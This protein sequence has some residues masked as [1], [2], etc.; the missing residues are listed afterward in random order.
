MQKT[1]LLVV[2]DDDNIRNVVKLYLEKEDFDVCQAARGDE[3][4]RV[5]HQH[6]PALVLLDIMLPGIDGWKVLRQIRAHDQT[7]VIMLSAKDET[8]DKVLGLELGADDY[9]AKPFDP[10]ELLA[11]IKAVLRRAQ[12]TQEKEKVVSFPGLVVNLS[13]YSTVFM[14]K[15]VDMP[16]K[17]MELLYYLCCHPGKV[18][19]REQLLEAVWGFDVYVDSRTVDVHIKRLREK[20]TGEPTWQ[21]KTVWGVGY[22]FDVSQVN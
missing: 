17:E 18:F 10:S 14:D 9:I 21:I 20:L 19:T 7:P 11:R 8:L 6:T 5:F 13:E 22:K 15:R 12:G 4:M 2:E 3:A 16:P 1:K